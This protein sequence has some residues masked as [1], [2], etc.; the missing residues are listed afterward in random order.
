MKVEKIVIVYMI[1]ALMY[2][3]FRV[4]CLEDFARKSNESIKLLANGLLELK[5]KQ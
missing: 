1:I 5:E 3:T 4:L 2:L